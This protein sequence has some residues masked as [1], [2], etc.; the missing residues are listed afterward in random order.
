MPVLASGAA[1]PGPDRGI[2]QV[3]PARMIEDCMK[4][5]LSLFKAD[6]KKY[7]VMNSVKERFGGLREFY[8]S[9]VTRDVDFRIE[10]LRRLALA[11][12]TNE[13]A[14]AEALH[15]DL[16]K[17]EGEAFITETGIV[18]A[19][20]RMQIKNI[21][22]W[23]RPRR[24]PTPMALFPSSSRLLWEPKG[25]V[26]IM[27]P[28]NYPFQLA[29]DPLVGAIA[30]GN[31]VALKPSATSAAASAVM[32]KIISEAF[33]ENYVAVFDRD[34][35]QAAELLHQRFDHIFFTGGSAFGRT[36]MTEAAR[37]LVPV[38]LEL[39]GK[40]PCIVDRGADTTI[41]ARR[42][43]WGK[44][45]NA[46]QTCIAPDYLFVHR[47]LKDELVGKMIAEAEHFYGPDP[48]ESPD[49]PRIISDKAF[50]RLTGYLGNS[51]NILYG[52]KA[53]PAERYIAPTF[54]ECPDPDCPVMQEEIFG[55]ILPI[56]EFGDMQ[57]VTDYVN[58]H[59]KPLALYYFGPRK[60]ARR[61]LA[62]TSSGGACVNDTLMHIAN[63]HLPFGG[64]GMSGM[65]R[66]HG[67]WSFETF[68][69]PRGTVFSRNRPD[70]KLRY[71]PY[72][73]KILRKLF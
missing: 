26:L 34:H 73:I 33:P 15:A 52:G 66:Y 36:V 69:N 55:P 28:W 58:G 8:I 65:G 32:K 13:K 53:D 16:R 14:I 25:V 20:I 24:V 42:I 10:S 1:G 22:R 9:G 44:L 54:L 21:R 68:S 63:G 30:A 19:E 62:S 41:A 29:M 60:E 5:V 51:G 3:G 31:C 35:K 59:E 43:V 38:T 2:Q 50:D 71:P 48:K 12:K 23:A 61:V 37:N 56:L 46:G 67:R 7:A 49:Y 40:S 6:S 27:A 17:S 47:S 11:I 57:T 39:G 4:F 18:L 70:I 45:V 72:N 64:V